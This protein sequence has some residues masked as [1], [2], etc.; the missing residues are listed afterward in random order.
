[1]SAT[2]IT[3]PRHNQRPNVI[4]VQFDLGS[5][6]LA[7]FKGQ[8]FASRLGFRSKTA[9]EAEALRLAESGMIWRM[10]LNGTV[11]ITPDE[12][13][14]GCWAV[15]HQD[16][17]PATV[18]GRH[19]SIDTAIPHAVQAATEMRAHLDIH[20]SIETQGGAA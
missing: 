9:A 6:A 13:G 15:C 2:I 8:R 18:L 17:S 12:T 19:L 11:Y 5:W 10:G 3:F 16:Q 7:Y 14:G 4:E 20:G 1:M